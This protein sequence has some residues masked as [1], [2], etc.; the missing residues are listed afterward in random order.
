MVWSSTQ[1]ALYKAVD[2]FNS[3][4]IRSEK[5][6]E[7][8]G[9][10]FAEKSPEKRCEKCGENLHGNFGK[11]TRNTQANFL[12]N[13]PVSKIFSDR[14]MLLIAGLILILISEKAD[15]ELIMA[16]AFVLLF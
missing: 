5:Y 12:R 15:T 9:E 4:E 14:D 16:L 6:R 13:D 10:K 11:N 7:K 3:C 1:S 8:R 2:D